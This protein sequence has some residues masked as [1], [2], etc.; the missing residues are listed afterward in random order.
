[1]SEQPNN[2]DAQF[3]HDQSGPIGRTRCTRV[4]YC[5]CSI[6]RIYYDDRLSKVVEVDNVTYE[7]VNCWPGD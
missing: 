6:I 2:D 4:Q 5:D 1:M 3:S 7:S